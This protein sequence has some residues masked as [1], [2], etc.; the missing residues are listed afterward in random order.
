MEAE[1]GP[2]ALLYVL[3]RALSAQSTWFQLTVGITYWKIGVGFQS[4]DAFDTGIPVI[5]I[6]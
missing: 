3:G 2:K 5:V 6:E 1:F 4:V